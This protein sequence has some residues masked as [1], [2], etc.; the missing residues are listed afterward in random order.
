[1]DE[2]R[3]SLNYVVS[4]NGVVQTDAED[5][6]AVAVA[7]S[8]GNMAYSYLRCLGLHVAGGVIGGARRGNP[9][10]AFAGYIVG[11]VLGIFT[12]N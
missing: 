7:S 6:A 4:P 9:W 12:C 2:P 1:M 3:E 5:E 10:S 8:S 11:G